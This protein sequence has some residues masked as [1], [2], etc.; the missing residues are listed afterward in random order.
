M[1]SVEHSTRSGQCPGETPRAR[2]GII[3]F[4]QFIQREFHHPS[5]DDLRG[6]IN[7]QVLGPIVR[8]LSASRRDRAGQ[9]AVSVVTSRKALKWPPLRKECILGLAFRCFY[10]KTFCIVHSVQYISFINQ[11]KSRI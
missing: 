7:F 11:A 6:Q 2:Y 10:S 9:R 5:A 3:Q 4:I 8:V 1:T